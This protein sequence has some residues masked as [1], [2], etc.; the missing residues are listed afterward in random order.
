MSD[1]RI[2]VASL[3]DYNNSILHGRWIDA[4]QDVQAINDEIAE[5][6]KESPAAQKYGDVAEEYAIHDYDGF[7]DFNLGEYESL[8]KITSIA[9]AL[10][11]FPSC[12]VAWFFRE[13]SHME[14]DEIVDTIREKSITTIEDQWGNETD[15]L[16]EYLFD[17]IEE[18]GDLPEQYKNH[19]MA[20]AKSMA[21]DAVC[22]GE[23][24]ILYE[25]GGKYH[26]FEVL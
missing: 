20:I 17:Q 6:L 15:A 21:H 24:N 5:M 16:A 14:F 18:S 2:Y 3:S 8:E 26:I 22:G 10:D 12:V 9:K 4:D 23:Y 19:Q 11:E 1:L 13:C 25:G 7:G